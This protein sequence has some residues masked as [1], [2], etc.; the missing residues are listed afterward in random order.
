MLRAENVI[1]PGLQKRRLKLN[2][3]KK[4]CIYGQAINE[5]LLVRQFKK[6]EEKR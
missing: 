1:L 4:I 5:R 2:K 3:T 6:K